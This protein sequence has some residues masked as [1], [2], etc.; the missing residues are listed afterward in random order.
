MEERSGDVKEVPDCKLQ[1]PQIDQAYST[2]LFYPLSL[3]I[4]RD[5]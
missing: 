3:G 1:L 4:D 5:D 2:E